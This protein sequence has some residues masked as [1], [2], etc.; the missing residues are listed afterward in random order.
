MA[1]KENDN[2]IIV[3]VSDTANLYNRTRIAL[4]KNDFQ[5]KENGNADTLSTFPREYK[6]INGYVIVNVAIS[7]NTVTFYG[8][9]GMGYVNEFGF[10]RSPKKYKDVIYFKGSKTWPLL[11]KIANELGGTLTYSQ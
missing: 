3:T 8:W 7:G 5:I 1:Q 9:Y 11:L 10:N 6:S 2:K 4:G